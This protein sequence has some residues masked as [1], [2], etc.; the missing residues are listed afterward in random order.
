MLNYNKTTINVIS[1]FISL[2]IF[3]SIIYFLQIINSNNLSQ[4]EIIYENKINVKQNIEPITKNKDIPLSEIKN[5]KISIEKLQLEANIK[6]GINNIQEN[7][8]HYEESQYLHGNI[9]LKAYNTGNSK[10]YFANLKELEIGDEIVYT[11]NEITTNYKVIS[12]IIIDNEYEYIKKQYNCDTITLITYIKD[13][14]N[15]MRCVIAEKNT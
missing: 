10:N 15:K 7:I 3:L 9:A 2:I 14:D 8:V 4:T 11:V 12:N 6:E 5:W 1:F 13:L